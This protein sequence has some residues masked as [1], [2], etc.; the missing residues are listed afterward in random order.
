MKDRQDLIYRALRNLGA[1]PMGQAPSA[2][3]YQS[4]SDIVD[5]VIA[6]LEALDNVYIA[7]ADAIED[8][9]FLALGHIVAWKAAPE[10]GAASDQ[11][12]AALATQATLTLKEM[13]NRD[14]SY[15]HLRTMQSDYPIGYSITSAS[16]LF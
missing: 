16:T 3:D 5:C 13:D 9:Y 1:L 10:F 8:E 4:I 11:A 14:V 6:E 7:S 12:L 15:R 2:E